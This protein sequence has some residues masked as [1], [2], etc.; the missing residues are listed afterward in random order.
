METTFFLLDAFA[1]T[2]LVYNSLQSEKRP[3]GSPPKGRFR[4][5]ETRMAEKTRK[6]PDWIKQQ[7][8]DQI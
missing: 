1:I 3:P 4:Y 5:S 6:I 8:Q 2:L 7:Q